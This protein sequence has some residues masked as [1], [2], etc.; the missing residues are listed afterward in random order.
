MTPDDQFPN[1]RW[2]IVL[3]VQGDDS[4][5]RDRALEQICRAY[6][7][8]VYAFAKGLG[9]QPSDAEDLTQNV[10]TRL[11]DRKA[12]DKVGAHKG[13]L[14]SFLRVATKNYLRDEWKKA[15]AQ[16]RG[17]GRRHSHAHPYPAVVPSPIPISS[18]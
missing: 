6:W 1:T 16:K 4:G 14:R 7:L 2:S 3:L 9:L 13:K 8:P 12:F 10:L 18:F 15:K 5:A 17:E 11:L